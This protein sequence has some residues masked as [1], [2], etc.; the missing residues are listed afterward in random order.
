MHTIQLTLY[1]L[2]WKVIFSLSVNSTHFIFIYHN[3]LSA[4]SVTPLENI[5]NVSN[6]SL[7]FPSSG[8]KAQ[9][10]KYRVDGSLQGDGG[11]VYQLPTGQFLAIWKS[12]S[13]ESRQSIYR[14]AG[15]TRPGEGK[16][17]YGHLFCLLTYQQVFVQEH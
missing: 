16:G 1:M 8:W 12:G 10:F 6:K 3:L 17:G 5:W 13:A 11:L 2:F 15:C 7:N 4:I 9:R 14:Q